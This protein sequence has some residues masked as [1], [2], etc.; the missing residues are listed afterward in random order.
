[1][2]KILTLVL[3]ACCVLAVDASRK[4]DSEYEKEMEALMAD[5][6]LPLEQGDNSVFEP[7]SNLQ[8]RYGISHCRTETF[9]NEQGVPDQLG[10]KFYYDYESG[11]SKYVY[12]VK[13]IDDKAVVVNRPGFIARHLVAGR[14]DM[15]VFQD[16]KDEVHDVLLKCEEHKSYSTDK[17]EYYDIQDMFAGVW[18][19]DS[20]Q[21]AVFGF[22]S[23]LEWEWKYRKPGKDF[24][25]T[26]TRRNKDDKNSR[27]LMLYFVKERV[28]G[29]GSLDIEGGHTNGYRGSGS[30]QG[31]I[32]WWLKDAEGNLAVELDKPYDEELDAWYSK[33]RDPQFTLH[34][35]RSPYID[36]PNRWAVLSMR[37]VTRGM[38]EVFDKASLQQMLDYLND[39]ENPTD[40]ERLNKSLIG[41]LLS[42]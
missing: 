7:N 37:P 18:A 21:V 31:P 2:R 10:F 34:W 36:N 42:E 6:Q 28:K 30:M 12:K 11:D 22:I 3:L 33:F 38:L 4:S 17:A 9:K 32:L 5:A 26:Y 23:Q 16:E 39:R 8:W 27:Q 15:I 29:A 35:V 20:N 13:L 24:E 25:M 1:M 40:I 19:N 41:T 14:W